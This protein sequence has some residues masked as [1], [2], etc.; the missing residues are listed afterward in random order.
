MVDILITGFPRSG[1][2]LVTSLLNSQPNVIALAEPLVVPEGLDR[3]AAVAYI[4]SCVAQFRA[5]ALAGAPL[6]TKHVDGKIPDNWVEPPQH[7][8]ILRRVLE[9]WGALTFDKPLGPDFTLAVKHPAEFTALADL[10]VAHF[11]IYT[12]VRDP[13]TVLA[14][15]Q[16]VDMPVNRG[17][18]PNLE[19]F[20]PAA[21]KEQL[22]AIGDP[23]ERQVKLLEFQLRTYL[24]LPNGRVL[25]YEDLV[26]DPRETLAPIC[27]G[28]SD[29]P[30][31]SAFDPVQRY[32]GVD[33]AALMKRLQ[34]LMPMVEHLYPDFRDRWEAKLPARTMVAKGEGNLLPQASSAPGP[35]AADAPRAFVMGAY[36]PA[37]GTHMAYEIG[38]VASEQ[39]GMTCYAVQCAAENP[40]ESIFE[41]PTRFA[42]VTREA[43]PEMV[44]PQDVLICN[45]SFSNG[46]V[47]LTH[48]C[49][50]LMYVQGF[51]TFAVLDRWF[52][53][54]VAVGGFV[55][56]FLANVYGLEAPIIRPFVDP[57][58]AVSPFWWNRAPNSVWFYLKGDEALQ[59]ALL[60]RLRQEV[61]S[62]DA[63]VASA[64]DWEGAILRAGDCKQPE[65]LR[66]L[67]ERRHL[68]TLAVCEGF[69]LVPLEAMAM[70]T[71]VLGFDGFGGRDYM[72]SGA[73]C[74]VH[75]Y[76][77]LTGIAQ[78]LVNAFRYPDLAAAIAGRGQA[79][80]ARYSRDR[81][82]K[83]WQRELETLI[84]R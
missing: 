14:A 53:R 61:R 52:D 11:P 22:D 48:H 5:S 45:P 68:V 83:A 36:I 64:V 78:D 60:A 40:D 39:I 66:K 6:P 35:H 2:T 24:S 32:A 55:Q 10:L 46:I 84:A 73:N 25:R 75:P 51:S 57:D 21:W 3:H 42:T 82:R 18:M 69:G 76:P 50:K 81:F 77:N 13:L 41:Y 19:R 37:G 67:G 79:T 62:I 71:M 72:R 27:P 70:G 38:R 80:A 8:G 16:T 26:A 63:G 30:E 54:H 43:L 58:G 33:F 34:P 7:H 23:L 47:G 44:R 4:V 20:A 31:C 17:H 49:R 1:T 59:T 12:M 65:L 29:Y 56:D 9:Q 74:R 15:W 28:T